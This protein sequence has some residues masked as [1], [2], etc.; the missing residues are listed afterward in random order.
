MSAAAEEFMKE[1]WRGHVPMQFKLASTSLAGMDSER[2]TAFYKLV[3][4]VG[5][6]EFCLADVK[7]HF[8]HAVQSTETVWLTREQKGKEVPVPWH[9]PLG[10]IFDQ[11]MLQEGKETQEMLPFELTVHFSAPTGEASGAAAVSEDQILEQNLKQSHCIRFGSASAVQHLTGEKR[12]EYLDAVRDGNYAQYANVRTILRS[13][14]NESAKL[15][16]MIHYNDHVWLRTPKQTTID[17]S[18]TLAEYLASVLPN[19]TV[20][21]GEDGAAEPT[22][23][24]LIH[25]VVPQP[26]TPVVWLVEYMSHPDGFLHIMIRSSKS[27]KK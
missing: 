7:S 19:E 11:W 17:S 6:L 3:P 10:V 15:P 18:P 23:G 12:T 25:G 13:S 8:Q 14:E 1:L 2:P 21:P 9:F 16:I 22:A 24:L 5:Y 27:V 26:A 20:F 4:R